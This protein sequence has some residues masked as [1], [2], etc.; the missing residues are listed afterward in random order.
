L[1]AGL[2]VLHNYDS[3]SEVTRLPY[4]KH[5][6]TIIGREEIDIFSKIIFPYTAQTMA[7][8]KGLIR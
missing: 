3:K 5:I 6:D 1:A 8:R 7:I 4:V 2:Q